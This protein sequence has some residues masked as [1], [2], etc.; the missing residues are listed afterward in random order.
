MSIMSYEGTGQK[1]RNVQNTDQKAYFMYF[2]VY[3]SVT[4]SEKFVAWM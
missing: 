1:L 3:I 2:Y 4:V